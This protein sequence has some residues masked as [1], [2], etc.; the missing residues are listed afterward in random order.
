[1]KNYTAYGL[2]ICSSFDLPELVKLEET[3]PV[4]VIVQKG[5]VD[6]SRRPQGAEGSDWIWATRDEAC[7]FIKGTG[8][9]HVQGGKVMTVDLASGAEEALMRLYLL[10]PGLYLLLH[11]RGYLLL[12]AS[13]IELPGGAVAFVANKGTGKSTLAAAFVRRGMPIV[14]DDLIAVEISGSN[15]GNGIPIVHPGFPQ[16]KLLPDALEGLGE[17]PQALPKINSL[18]D[19]RARRAEKFADRALPLR[20]VYVLSEGGQR[21]AI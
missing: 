14:A 2:G 5:P 10:G 17:N 21:Q 1:M 19:K 18:A 20:R 7:L 16:M 3:R 12:H 9:F 15:N 6:F 13:C 8:G 4:D 11:Q